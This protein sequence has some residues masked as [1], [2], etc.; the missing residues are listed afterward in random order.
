MPK[1][2]SLTSMICL[3]LTLVIHGPDYQARGRHGHSAAF[4]P[5][6]HRGVMKRP[7]PG[8]RGHLHTVTEVAV[9]EHV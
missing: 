6:L 4:C 1:F 2:L 5:Q 7:G 9:V 3:A 8:S